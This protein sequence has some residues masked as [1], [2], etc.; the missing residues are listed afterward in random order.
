M[1]T[2]INTN[3]PAPTVSATGGLLRLAVLAEVGV[4]VILQ[5]LLARGVVAEPD[6]TLLTLPGQILV[7][8]PHN[9]RT[10]PVRRVNITNVLIT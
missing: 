6:T 8:E 5:L 7:E 10:L 3:E 1:E 9:W 4:E 2:Y